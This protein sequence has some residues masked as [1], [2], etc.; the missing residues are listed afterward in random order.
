[1]QVD[2]DKLNE[3]LGQVVGE[4]GSAVNAA[5][6]FIGEEL[7]LYKA[8]A[9]APARPHFSPV[10][11]ELLRYGERACIW[12]AEL[13]FVNRRCMLQESYRRLLPPDG[14]VV[15]IEARDGAR[16]RMVLRAETFRRELRF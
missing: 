6:A 8:I 2:K 4:L 3:F 9:G 1:M 11:D 10:K 12:L 14:R 15:E 16:L 5:L 13:F 7:G